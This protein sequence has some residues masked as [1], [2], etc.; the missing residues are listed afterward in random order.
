MASPPGLTRHS[1]IFTRGDFMNL[2]KAVKRYGKP[3]FADKL[4]EELELDSEELPLE[5]LMDNAGWMNEDGVDVSVQ[6]FSD[7]GET[8]TANLMILFSED[9]PSGCSELTRTDNYRVDCVVTIDM[10][11]GE[12]EFDVQNSENTTDSDDDEGDDIEEFDIYVDDEPE[13]E[14]AEERDERHHRESEF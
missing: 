10:E 4:A 12:A 13:E 11:T 5:D 3:D 7:D 8:I 1:G 14:S 6:N 9:H 2:M